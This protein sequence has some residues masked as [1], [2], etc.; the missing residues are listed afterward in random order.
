VIYLLLVVFLQV[1]VSGWMEGL[2]NYAL[3]GTTLAVVVLINPLRRRIQD[4]I[5]RRFYRNKYDAE[6]ALERFAALARDE[7]DINRLTISLTAVVQEV[8]QPEQ[9]SLWLPVKDAAKV[10]P[11]SAVSIGLGRKNR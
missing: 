3:A 6:K 9:V 2:P 4:A 7:A 5:D 11:R 10:T 1:L 8:L